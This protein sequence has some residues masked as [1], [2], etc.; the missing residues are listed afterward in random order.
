MVVGR[1]LESSYCQLSR[2]KQIDA[3]AVLLLIV[4]RYHNIVLK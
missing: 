1:N 4:K 2:L 3:A